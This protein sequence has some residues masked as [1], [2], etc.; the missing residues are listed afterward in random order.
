VH[1]PFNDLSRS[2]TIS[3]DFFAGLM[4]LIRTGHYLSGPYTKSFENT[5]SEYLGVPF[6]KAVSSGTSALVLALKS[7]RLPEGSDVLMTANSGAYSRIAAEISN[8]N[9]VY[10]D[11]ELDGLLTV[12]ALEKA[13]TENT[14]ALIVTHLYG[15]LGEMDEIYQFCKENKVYLVED[16][17]QA[18]GAKRDGRFAGSWGDVSAFSFYPTKNLG[19][20]GD[21]GAVATS[22]KAIYEKI[23]KLSQYG[24][25]AKYSIE[26]KGGENS[27]IDEIQAFILLKRLP[28]LDI[29]N[30]RRRYIWEKYARAFDGS[31]YG[32]IG[33][34]DESFVAHLAVVDAKTDRDAFREFLGTKGI[35]TA[36]HYPIPD[37][38][39][40]G[41]PNDQLSL[42][43]TEYLAKSIFSLP[44]FPELTKTEVDYVCSSITEFISDLAN[45]RKS[46]E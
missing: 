35:H 43:N 26:M 4:E 21:A 18:L 33:H 39:Q 42:P 37:H 14:K 7:L 45:K 32:L 23:E 10:V 31:G 11:V 38:L 8:L 3:E 2:E 13:A 22:S 34:P 6:V 28:R 46:N 16:C 36:I 41:F 20:M 1:L 30:Q 9:S 17:A 5:L 29:S 27:R 15:Q 19:A 12:M 44:L 40:I 25:G 24:W